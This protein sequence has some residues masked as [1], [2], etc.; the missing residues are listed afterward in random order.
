MNGTDGS[1]GQP[2]EPGR[3]VV[4]ETASSGECSAGGTKFEVE[5]SG[6]PEHVCNGSGGSG[7]GGGT[8]GSG[9]TETGTWYIEGTVPAEEELVQGSISFTTPLPAPATTGQ[10]AHFEY[11]KQ[12]YPTPGPGT[13]NCPGSWQDPTAVPGYFCVY[14]LGAVEQNVSTAQVYNLE[15]PADSAYASRFGAILRL[16]SSKEGIVRGTGA[17]AVTAN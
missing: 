11:V 1:N 5:G 10:A 15:N 4:A 2:G 14:S 9:Q 12:A 13:A 8:L 7:G 16:E 6:H 17:W 3:S